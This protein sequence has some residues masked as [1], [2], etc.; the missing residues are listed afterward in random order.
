MRS[1]WIRVIL[2]Y[3]SELHLFDGSLLAIKGRLEV[4][5]EI[6][7]ER[8]LFV[9]HSCQQIVQPCTKQPFPNGS[10]TVVI[11]NCELGLA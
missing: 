1:W 7:K 2:Y 11:Y 9:T 6:C 5:V 8:R 10:L 3:I 4:H